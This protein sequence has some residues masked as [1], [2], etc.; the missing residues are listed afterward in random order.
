MACTERGAA[1]RFPQRFCSEEKGELT[2]TQRLEKLRRRLVEE[3]LDGILISQMENCR[4]LSGF[5]GSAGELLIT[6]DSAILITDFRYIE[7]AELQAPDF[8]VNQISG[9]TKEHRILELASELGA[10]RL[11]FEASNLC[12]TDYLHLKEEA[13][14]VK[15]QIVPTQGLVESL[16]TVKEEK[17]ID[18]LVKAVE[19]AHQLMSS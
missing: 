4:Y 19:L 5:S 10:K 6:P 12:F 11:G 14:K 9:E 17:E 3:E 7:Q 1:L 16:R 2:I 15:T 18:F 13:E 8:K